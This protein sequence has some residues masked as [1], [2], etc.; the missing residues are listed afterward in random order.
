METN[1]NKV[2]ETAENKYLKEAEGILVS[3]GMGNLMYDVYDFYDLEESVDIVKETMIRY[4]SAY[5]KLKKAE[6]RYL[7]EVNSINK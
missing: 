7:D 2:L 5:S 6:K 4:Q 1:K 3:Y